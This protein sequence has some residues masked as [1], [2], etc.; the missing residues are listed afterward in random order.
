MSTRAVS[1]EGLTSR[2]SSQGGWGNSKGL[3]VGRRPQFFSHG[4]LHDFPERFLTRTGPTQT[5][6]E[7]EVNP[8]RHLRPPPRHLYQALL[9]TQAGCHSTW[10]RLHRVM[11]RHSGARL[12]GGHLW[13]WLP[14]GG[15]NINGFK[16]LSID[17]K[18][19]LSYFQNSTHPHPINRC[20]CFQL[21]IEILELE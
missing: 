12:T 11:N 14:L 3:A 5:M 21:H 16:M 19:S 10:E 17:A 9:V 2:V 15:S 1:S 13:D 4:L 20:F 18:Y 7:T 6:Q 8:Q